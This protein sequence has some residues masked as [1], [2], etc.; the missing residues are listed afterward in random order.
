MGSHEWRY[1]NVG[2]AVD[3]SILKKETHQG[4]AGIEV[5]QSGKNIGA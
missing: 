3:N 1:G 5:V 4:Y 2:D